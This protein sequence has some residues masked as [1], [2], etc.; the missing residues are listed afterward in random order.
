MSDTEI[1]GLLGELLFM[2]DHMIP[3]YGVA[4]ALASWMGPEKTHK[5]FSTENMWYEIKTINS[6]KTTVRISSLEQLD[7]DIE[8]QLVVYDLEK[9]SPSFNSEFSIN[10]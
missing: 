7:G 4:T 5:D 3:Q 10:L 1:V 8:G 2:D 9:M 6:G